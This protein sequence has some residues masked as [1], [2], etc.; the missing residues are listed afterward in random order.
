M[1]FSIFLHLFPSSF[2]FCI[3]IFRL[4]SVYVTNLAWCQLVARWWIIN[5]FLDIRN[6]NSRRIEDRVQRIPEGPFGNVYIFYPWVELRLS[7]LR[8]PVTRGLPCQLRVMLYECGAIGGMLIGKANRRTRSNFSQVPLRQPQISHYLT[9][10]LT[11]ANAVEGQR[12]TSLIWGFPLKTFLAEC[13]SPNHI[14]KTNL[15]WKGITLGVNICHN[16]YT[17]CCFFHSEA[18]W[19]TYCVKRE[20]HWWKLT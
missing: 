19:L 4:I 9:W 2:P 18:M 3:L 17:N 20:F 1:L 16:S 8:T 10:D 14:L 15:K 11:R 13:C 6:S 12:L 7:P 5:T